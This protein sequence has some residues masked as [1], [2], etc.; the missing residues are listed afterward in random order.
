MTLAPRARSGGCTRPGRSGLAARR[1]G[2]GPR[3]STP[4]KPEKERDTP[5]TSSR[6]RGPHG[7]P[8]L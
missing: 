3:T 5:F 6:R 8:Q 4:S 1:R 2:H 7:R